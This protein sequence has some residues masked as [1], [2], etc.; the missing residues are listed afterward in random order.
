M[1]TLIDSKFI[2]EAFRFWF[3]DQEHIRSPFPVY[4]QSELKQKTIKKFNEWLNG[5]HQ[6]AKDE[7]NDEMFAEKFEEILFEIA[8][9]L[10]ITEDEKITILYPF[11]PRL[12][13]T[14]TKDNNES[15]IV[16]RNIKVN[17]DYKS[18]EIKCLENISNLKWITSFELPN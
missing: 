9:E 13:D 14:T 1:N 2:E 12:N 17:G 3:I 15:V 16:E 8:L 7:F 6:D 11:L 18:L 10:V 5:I 4:I